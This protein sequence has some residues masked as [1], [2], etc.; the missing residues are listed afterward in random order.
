MTDVTQE[1]M[2]PHETARWFRCSPSWLR[3][4]NRLLRIGVSGG[5]P[6]FHVRV[7]RAYVLGQ[8]CGLDEA[9]LRHVQI[10]A[11]TAAC[12]LPVEHRPDA[13]SGE[14]GAVPPVAATN[15]RRSVAPQLVE[16][17]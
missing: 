7:C 15:R 16:Q 5:Q 9:G 13:G 12:G 10:Q 8:L 4:Q 3:Q 14:Q 1:L 11:L 2:T 17:P 6:L